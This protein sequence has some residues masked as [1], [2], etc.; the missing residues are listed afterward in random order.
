MPPKGLPPC[1]G[2]LPGDV[3]KVL[4]LEQLDDGRTVVI[5]EAPALIEA[6]GEPAVVLETGAGCM[7]TLHEFTLQRSYHQILTGPAAGR[8]GPHREANACSSGGTIQ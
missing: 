2:P 5:C 7:S 8:T 3:L 1:R 4:R 6:P